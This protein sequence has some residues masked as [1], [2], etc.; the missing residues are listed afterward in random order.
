MVCVHP[1]DVCNHDEIDSCA[2]P[3]ALPDV[4]IR[5]RALF[6]SFEGLCVLPI[7]RDFNDCRQDAT[8]LRGVEQSDRLG[9]H[10]GFFKP[11]NSS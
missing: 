1:I 9:N 2:H 6:E 8:H 4:S 11:G 5:G 3:V 7:E 10:P